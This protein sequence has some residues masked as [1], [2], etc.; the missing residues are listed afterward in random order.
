MSSIEI[1]R[2]LDCFSMEESS[3]VFVNLWINGD[4]KDVS[5]FIFLYILYR[6]VL[7][8][9]GIICTGFLL[10]YQLKCT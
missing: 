9:D 5:I 6:M 4:G 8:G 7:S 3:S 2:S 10:K 1:M